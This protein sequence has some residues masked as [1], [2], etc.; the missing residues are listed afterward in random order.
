VGWVERQVKVRGLPS[1]RQERG[2]R[3]GHPHIEWPG[4]DGLPKTTRFI[5]AV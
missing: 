2:A 5:C 4:E 1:L 3:M